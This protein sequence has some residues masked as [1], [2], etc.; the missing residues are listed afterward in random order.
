MSKVSL[1]NKFDERGQ[2]K[3]DLHHQQSASAKNSRAKIT[4]NK[5][6]P[7]VE[8]PFCLPAVNV[9]SVNGECDMTVLVAKVLGK[10]KSTKS[11]VNPSVP[12]TPIIKK[13][14]QTWTVK[15]HTRQVSSTS[16]YDDGVDPV[17][18]TFDLAPQTSIDSLMTPANVE[19]DE[20]ED[21][22]S[23]MFAKT[24]GAEKISRSSSRYVWSAGESI[25]DVSEV[26]SSD[27]SDDDDDR[28]LPRPVQTWCRCRLGCR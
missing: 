1:S 3:D 10:R 8:I 17:T 20:D 11:F 18:C 9:E 5:V 15:K 14:D 4:N 19:E 26:S 16:R 6:N 23:T 22:I 12:A 25:D 21:W 24:P 13:K 2:E 28:S 27:A 7:P